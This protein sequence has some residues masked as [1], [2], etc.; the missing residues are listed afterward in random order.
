[1]IPVKYLSH[2]G[3]YLP[4]R[5]RSKFIIYYNNKFIPTLTY[6]KFF[7]LTVDFSLTWVNHIDSQ[8]KN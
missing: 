7:S 3:D 2:V 5:D 8:K 1:M 4:Q 6:T